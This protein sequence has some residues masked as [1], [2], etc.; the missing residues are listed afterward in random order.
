VSQKN[1]PGH[2]M[3][4]R[5]INKFTMKEKAQWWNKSS[6]LSFLPLQ[7]ETSAFKNKE[8]NLQIHYTLI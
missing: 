3:Y 6:T 1:V 4:F 7:S 8:D 5:K 2:L